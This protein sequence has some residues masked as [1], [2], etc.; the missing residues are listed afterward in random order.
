VSLLKCTTCGEGVR[1]V[2]T[3]RGK[4]IPL[5]P[6]R[7]ERHGNFVIKKRRAHYISDAERV[8]RIRAGEPVWEYHYVR[9]AGGTV[10]R[11]GRRLPSEREELDAQLL[12]AVE[13]DSRG[14]AA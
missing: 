12:E 7:D 9:C 2:R 6:A 3:T 5:S 1:I 11:W 4:T 8:R 10:D 13:R 14:E